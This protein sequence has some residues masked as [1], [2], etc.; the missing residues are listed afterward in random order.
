MALAKL[1]D[2]LQAQSAQ[3]AIDS[4]ATLDQYRQKNA[5]EK[6]VLVQEEAIKAKKAMEEELIH[7]N[8]FK[9]PRC[10]RIRA[11][12]SRRTQCQ[13]CCGAACPRKESNQEETKVC[14]H[15][16]LRR[17]FPKFAKSR[18]GLTHFQNPEGTDGKKQSHHQ[19][20]RVI[21]SSPIPT[22]T[23][24][25]AKL[26]NKKISTTPPTTNS[27]SIMVSVIVENSRS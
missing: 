25:T 12:T 15:N 26:L 17:L 23:I 8:G 13:S 7:P 21:R 10:K 3:E 27:K 24:A 14:G 4:K 16:R 11:D 18:G 5:E 6:E 19:R 1:Q 22:R 20:N 9:R 2:N